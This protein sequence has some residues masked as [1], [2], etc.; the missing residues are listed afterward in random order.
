ML[1]LEIWNLWVTGFTVIFGIFGLI[2]KTSMNH[3]WGDLVMYALYIILEVF[4]FVLSYVRFNHP[5][6]RKTLL[7]RRKGGMWEGLCLVFAC[8]AIVGL[9][10]AY[11][12][13]YRNPQYWILAVIGVIMIATYVILIKRMYNSRE[14][15]LTKC[16]A[17]IRDIEKA[18]RVSDTV[19]RHNP[20]VNPDNTV[21]ADEFNEYQKECQVG[22]Q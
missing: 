21:D 2:T 18:L 4:I 13:S 8:V 22:S 17:D 14:Y 6:Y 20:T 16:G 7:E 3:G 19:N 15:G 12:M 5:S 10:C 1:S 11:I 9:F